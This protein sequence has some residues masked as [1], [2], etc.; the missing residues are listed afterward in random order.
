MTTT[1]L[2]MNY[3]FDKLEWESFGVLNTQMHRLNEFL[4]FQ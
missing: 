4:Y 1:N 2:S 3:F